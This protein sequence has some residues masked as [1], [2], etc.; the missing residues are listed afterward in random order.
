M[1]I[2]KSQ[3]QQRAPQTA[4]PQKGETEAT[5]RCQAPTGSAGA[6]QVRISSEAELSCWK[7]SQEEPPAPR[8]L[9]LAPSANPTSVIPILAFAAPNLGPGGRDWSLTPERWAGPSTAAPVRRGTRSQS[10]GRNLTF[11][12]D[13]KVG[14]KETYK[15]FFLVGAVSVPILTPH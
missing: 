11:L 8:V 9:S 14:R 10:Q 12:R 5:A 3:K 13:S 15:P 1:G 4:C 6:K 7:K 2:G